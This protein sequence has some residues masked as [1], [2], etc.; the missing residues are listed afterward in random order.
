MSKSVLRSPLLATNVK[1]I[2]EIRTQTLE[3]RPA[4]GYMLSSE[5]YMVVYSGRERLGG[6]CD[7]EMNEAISLVPHFV[8][9]VPQS[10]V[11]VPHW[12]VDVHRQVDIVYV[13]H[14]ARL[15]KKIE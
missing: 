4:D 9:A 15:P 12:N 7:R 8:V 1:Q 5:G 6:G 11:A 14:L 10:D 13:L 2:H 3:F